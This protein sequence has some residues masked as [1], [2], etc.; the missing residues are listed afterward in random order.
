M[1]MEMMSIVNCWGIPIIDLD[2]TAAGSQVPMGI[3]GMEQWTAFGQV[4]PFALAS[5]SAILKKDLKNTLESPLM[6]KKRDL[7]LWSG[8]RLM[9]W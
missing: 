7:F 4:H 8:A 3:S 5:L 6:G 1:N 9:S 2:L